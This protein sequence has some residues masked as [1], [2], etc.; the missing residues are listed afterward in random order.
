[1]RTLILISFVLLSACAESGQRVAY[2]S[3]KNAGYQQC[4]QQHNPAECKVS[5][6]YDSYQKDRKAMDKNGY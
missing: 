5:D 6:D 1:M 4:L 3:V 2:V